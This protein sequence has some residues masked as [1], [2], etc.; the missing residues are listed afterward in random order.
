MGQDDT[1]PSTRAAGPAI[2]RGFRCRCPNCGEGRL[3]RR[4]IEQVAHCAACKEPLA[5]YNVGLLLPLIV[6]MVVIFIIAFVMLA[7]EINGWGNPL[8]YL[9]V[10]VPLSVL[11]PLLILPPA[12]GAIIGLFW[13]KGWSD[14]QG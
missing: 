1:D 5:Q 9:V 8:I 2:W 3:F 7:L 4:Y 14:E 12:K 6:I 13:A 11:I 10:L